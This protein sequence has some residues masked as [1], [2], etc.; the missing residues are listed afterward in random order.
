M[1]W[2]KKPRPVIER[3]LVEP[4]EPR[5][6]YAADLAAGLMLAGMTDMADTGAEIRVLDAAGD[7]AS[8]VT[9]P[10]DVASAAQRAGLPLNFEINA[11]QADAAIDFIARGSGVGIALAGGNATLILKDGERSDVVRMT[12]AGA[13]AEV[14]GQTEGAVTSRSNY[15][16]GS[17]DQWLQDVANYASVRYDGVYAGIDLRYYGNG[18]ALEYDFS[19]AAG[20]DWRQI[21]LRFDGVD[22]VAIDADG[23]LRLTVE[24]TE[25]PNSLRFEAPVSYQT[26][27]AGREAVASRYV[28]GEDGK[29]RF[30]IGA[31]DASRALVIDPVL[32]YGSYLGGTGLDRAHGIAVDAAGNAYL[33]GE[34]ASAAFPTSAGVYDTSQNGGGDVFVTKLNATGTAVVY[35]TFIGGSGNDVA[36]GIAVDAAGNAYVTGSTTSSNLP[37]VNPFQNARAGT[38]DAFF[39]E[40]NASGTALVYSTYYGGGGSGE[41]GNA[42]ALDGAGNAYITGDTDSAGGIASAGAYDTTLGGSVDAFLVK[43]DP[44]QSGAA[45]RTFGTY[46]GGSSGGSGADHGLAVAVDTSGQAYVAGYTTANNF[47]TTASAYDATS[48]G[49]DDAFLA[50]FNAAG[51][52]LNYATY[53]GGAG[54]DRANAIALGAANQVYLSG[55][56]GSGFPTRNAYD[57]TYGGGA[58]DVIVAKF[59]PTLSGSASLIYATYLGGAGAE[60]ATGVAVDSLGRAHVTGYSSGSFTTTADALQ[61]SY[62]GGAND[63]FYATLGTLGNSLVYSTYLGGSADDAGYAV[64]RDG[65]D[66]IFIAGHTASANF[67]Q[68]TGAAYDNTQNGGDDAFVV[69]FSSQ[70]LTVTTTNDVVDGATTSIAAL[71]ANK[72]ADGLISLREAIIATNNTAGADAIALPAGTYQLTRAGAGEDAAATGDL[73]ILDV[74]TITGAGSA[75]TVVDGNA[76]DRVLHVQTGVSATLIDVTLRGGLLAANRWG[77]GV[78]VDNGASLGLSRVVITG[79]SAGSG[80]GLYNYGALTAS[81]TSFSGNAAADWG[82][83]LFNDRGA[84]LLDR[85]TISGNTAG[86]DGGGIYNFGSG[87]TLSLSNVTVSGNTATGIGGGVYTNRAITVTNSTI[88]FNSSTG[89]A[90]G[91]HVQGGGSAT[92]R[93]TLLFNPAGTNSNTALTSLG[94]NLD[95]DGT[96]G[97]AA[98]GDLSGTLGTPIDAKL[99]PLQVNGGAIATHSL[100]AGS[101]AINAGTNLGAAAIDGRGF[102]RTDGRNDIGAFEAGAGLLDKIYWADQFN[103]KIQRA[104]L[105][106]SNVEDV[107]TSANGVNSPTEVLIDLANGTIYWSENFAG[108]IRRANLDG[109]NIQTL[110]S[111]LSSPA[112]IA[113]DTAS[114]RLYWTENPILL[115]ANRIRSADMNGGGAIQN[116]VTTGT[117]DPVDLQLDLAAGKIYWTDGNNGEIRRANL[118][119]SGAAVFLSGLT[120]PQGL[121]LDL[122]ARMMYWA[123]DGLFGAPDKIQRA[124]LDGTVVV[125]DLVTAGLSAPIGIE[126]DLAAGKIYWS[127]YGASKI[128]SANLDGSNVQQ[129]VS[130]GISMLIGVALGPAV[131]ANDAPVITS[132]GGGASAG[133]SVA[134]NGI[135]VTTFTATDADL[136]AQTLTYSISGGAD[137]AR[138]SIGSAIDDVRLEAARE[139]GTGEDDRLQKI[140][141]GADGADLAEVRADAA[142]LVVDGVARRAQGLV[143][144]VDVAALFEAAAGGELHQFVDASFLLAGI[145]LQPRGQLERLLA[146]VVRALRHCFL[147]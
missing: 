105:D 114:S 19:V 107:L 83:G 58:S 77:G 97:L 68:I 33:T 66:N 4:L 100:L 28:L 140:A 103:N 79:N 145:D 75:T 123:S 31:Y 72:G 9:A 91:I 29:V 22:Q 146:N 71:L 128:Q 142:P 37:T 94:N 8:T 130:S 61:A 125:Q 49:G 39:L 89:G 85:V 144:E 65:A 99:G 34:T 24:G 115:G 46:L 47:P 60:T 90:D 110:Y 109:S 88:A 82:A 55:A 36:W 106:G 96:A 18:R 69:R 59:D 7:Y 20:A 112:G 32:V 53:L 95:S 57:A 25:G 38:Q 141:A 121:E 27:A 6:L 30:D 11:G 147:D 126:L 2:R 80:A 73:D 42:V 104:N 116:L 12:L 87:A 134:E 124:N 62:A 74:L 135:A 35:S 133:L 143:A 139:A 119:G 120:R 44:T 111:G 43:F 10:I 84:V 1:W 132:N 45:S 52:A 118:D 3:P 40:L 101:P 102:Q 21:A 16:V 64:A 23:A 93:N 129:V 14:R 76:L 127:D 86:K 15:L 5:I 137:A 117:N 48:N 136:P 56:A 98:A 41:V 108:N 70:A 78:L 138:F 131:D 51:S 13:A 26:G 17:R 63:V 92:L 81:D 113:L 50:V 122:G 54:D 67:Q